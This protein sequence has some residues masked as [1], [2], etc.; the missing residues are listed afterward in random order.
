MDNQDSPMNILQNQQHE[1]TVSR[2]YTVV[3]DFLYSTY[4][5]S[6]RLIALTWYV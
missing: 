3:Y 2:Q 4:I 6:I 5:A 1:F